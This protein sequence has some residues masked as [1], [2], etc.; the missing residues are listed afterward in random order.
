M[1]NPW[2]DV[3]RLANL[4]NDVIRKVLFKITMTKPQ[5]TCS[6]DENL[7]IPSKAGAIDWLAVL[8]STENTCEIQDRVLGIEEDEPI[9][10]LL[11]DINLKLNHEG[12]KN[13][14]FTG[15]TLNFVFGPNDYFDNEVWP[16]TQFYSVDF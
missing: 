13:S 15:F 6:R 2:A 10:A 5:V 11:K 7:N 3:A 1:H 12:E 9:L 16:L 8:R 14:V 4:A